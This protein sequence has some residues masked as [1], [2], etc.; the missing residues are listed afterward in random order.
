LYKIAITKITFKSFEQNAIK[1]P[2][3][4]AKK[5]LNIIAQNNASQLIHSI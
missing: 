1:I 4:D 3:K 2:I 5:E